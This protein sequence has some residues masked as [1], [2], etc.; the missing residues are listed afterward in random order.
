VL[1][2]PRGLLA[3]AGPYTKHFICP[4]LFTNYF[5]RKK[6]CDKMDGTNTAPGEVGVKYSSLNVKVKYPW[7]AQT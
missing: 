4:I 3:D 1:G 6:K 7:K 2:V 5:D